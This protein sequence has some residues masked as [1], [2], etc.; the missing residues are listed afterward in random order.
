MMK[1]KKVMIARRKK[2]LQKNR[3]SYDI[4]NTY[5]KVTADKEV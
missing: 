1:Q 5:L 3:L 4:K 2:T